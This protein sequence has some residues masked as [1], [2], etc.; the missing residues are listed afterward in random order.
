MNFSSGWAGPGR[1]SSFSWQRFLNRSGNLLIAFIANRSIKLNR[2]SKLSLP[3][4]AWN[5][6]EVCELFDDKQGPI[7]LLEEIYSS[8]EQEI[9]FRSR[10][11][12]VTNGGGFFKD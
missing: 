7:N 3:K 2:W 11:W 8:G 9:K 10:K 5:A 12:K 1:A 6:V 4:R